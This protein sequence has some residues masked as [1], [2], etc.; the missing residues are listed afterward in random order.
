MINQEQNKPVKTLFFGTSSF[1]VPTL[2]NLINF[3]Y[4]VKAVITQPEKPAGRKR[5]TIPSPVKKLAEENNISVFEPHDLKNDDFFK[6][7][8]NLEPDMCVLAAYGKIIPARYLDLP[9]YGFINIHPSLLPKY[10]GPSP[11]QNAILNG[12]EK[13]G[14]TIMK[15]D[16][17]IDHGPV[18]AVIGYQLSTAQNYKE[19]E[20]D[21]AKLGAELLIDVLPKYIS[22]ELKF[23]VQ[24]DAEATFT[25]LLNRDSGRINWNLSAKDIWNKTRALNPEPGTWTKW[26]GKVLNILDTEIFCLEKEEQKAPG[27]VMKIHN[28]LIAVTTKKCYLILKQIQLEGGKIMDAKSF[29]NG[30]P[31]FPG[32]VLE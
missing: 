10:R 21:L 13:T 1:A 26:N 27:T 6:Q 15:M 19:T 9:H 14:V 22:S 32:S 24:N 2:K 16:E 17:K 25:K 7:F 8:K 31:D 3:G 5:I 20:E 12:D 23:Q 4:N 18:L 30:H 11:I 28:G 29:L